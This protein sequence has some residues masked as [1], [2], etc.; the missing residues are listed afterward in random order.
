[1]TQYTRAPLVEAVVDIQFSDAVSMRELERLRDRFT[2]Q[3]PSIEEWAQYQFTIGANDAQTSRTLTGYK[4]TK[5]DATGIVIVQ[6]KGITSSA[7]A[8][9]PGW[10]ELFKTSK[11]N[12]DQLLKI[13]P[14]PTVVRIAAKFVN[15]ID[16][17]S[18]LVE[19]RGVNE[20][21][22]IGPAVPAG[23]ANAISSYSVALNFSEATSGADVLVH[24]GAAD[25][26][27][28]GFVSL[29]LDID[30]YSAKDIPSR[31]DEMWAK[32]ASFR[33]VKNRIFELSITDAVREVIK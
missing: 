31:F 27:L 26:L 3:Y 11:K 1:M 6:N 2:S 22:Q 5:T 9:Y 16:I 29:Q 21:V 8:P 20:F 4:L 7:L 30:V 18:K 28:I 33:E 19:G 10:N 23:L 17:P 12:F 15:R 24:A 14:H 32:I 13:V 25:P